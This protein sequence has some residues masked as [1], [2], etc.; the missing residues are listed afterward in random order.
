MQYI[1]HIAQADELML[2]Q[3]EGSTNIMGLIKSWLSPVQK[4]EDDLEAFINS[5]GISTAK[6]EMLDI[7]GSWMGVD[8]GS[9][10]DAQYKQAILT[11]A[12]LEL[13]NPST[14]SFYQS[15]KAVTGSDVVNFLENYP[16]TVYAHLGAG[17]DYSS[18]EQLKRV[19]KA[20]VNLVVMVDYNHDSFYMSE[21]I[22]VDNAIIDHTGEDY[23]LRTDGLD[24]TWISSS[25]DGVLADDS[26]SIM[27]DTIDPEGSGKVMADVL[28][29]TYTIVDG[30]IV[31][32][33]G[34][35]MVD[36]Q[37]NFFTYRDIQ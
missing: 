29:K 15:M 4:I 22:S 3:F 9:K 24:D 5:N 36:D 6:G 28:T 16:P 12:S 23:I 34:N 33:D 17:W 19:T 7:I 30:F 10:S 13:A 20:G 11:E 32:Q 2:S 31:D 26:G 14:V 37:G 35:R 27:A 21:I 18:Y 8:R 25:S 1:D